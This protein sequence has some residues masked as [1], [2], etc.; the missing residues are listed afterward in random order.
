MSNIDI[1]GRTKQSLCGLLF[2]VL[3]QFSVCAS[4]TVTLVWD[5]S[6]DPNVKG[7]K[8]YYGLASH[9]YTDCVDVKNVTSAQIAI[10]SSGAT[11]Y[12]A[13]TAY[14]KLGNESDSSNEA[15]YTAPAPATLTNLS[16]ST[17][18]FSF[19]ISGNPGSK[20]AVQA[21]TNLIDWLSVQTNTAPFTFVD[22]N[23]AGFGQRF[24]RTVSL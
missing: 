10:S 2:V 21:S 13:A 18:Q 3:I 11:Y 8:I 6:V 5:S 24:Y 16:N 12:F 19:M 14:D 1:I 23:A 22:T 20:Y 15:V 17:G 9:H 4:Q 7:Y